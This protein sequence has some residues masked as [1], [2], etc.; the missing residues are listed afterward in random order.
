MAPQD[1]LPCHWETR[2]KGLEEQKGSG[3]Q[4]ECRPAPCPAALQQ[5]LP[6]STQLTWR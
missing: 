2:G 3:M 1:H 6:A 5:T 4:I